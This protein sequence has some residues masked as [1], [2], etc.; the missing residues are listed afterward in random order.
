MQFSISSA[1]FETVFPGVTS[2]ATKK[3]RARERASRVSLSR[4]RL[5]L[6]SLLLSACYAGYQNVC[7]FL[8]RC[9]VS[10]RIKQ[11][12]DNKKVRSLLCPSF[13]QRRSLCTKS[14]TQTTSSPPFFLKDRRASETRARVKITPRQKRRHA[15]QRENNEGLQTKPKLLTIHGRLVLECE[16]RI[17]F[18]IN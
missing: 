16:V 17:P 13:K 15:A 3:K 4:A 14:S 8:G 5:F 18:Q 7:W 12:P 11:M 10:T 2:R 9:S 6:R 1:P